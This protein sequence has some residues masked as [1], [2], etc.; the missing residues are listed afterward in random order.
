MDTT[1]IT[2]LTRTEATDALKLLESEQKILSLWDQL[3][4]LQ[5]ERALLEIQPTIPQTSVT[6][7]SSD[8]LEAELEAAEKA[9]LEARTT[10]M[11]R[12]NITTNVLI[13]DPILK[14]VHEASS[15]NT[16]ERRLLPLIHE[17]DA[18][19]LTHSHLTSKLRTLQHQYTTVEAEIMKLNSE[20]QLLASQLFKLTDALKDQ[21][22]EELD[23]P[24][25][26]AELEG[27]DEAV[28][29]ARRRWRVMKS[30]VAGIVVGSGVEWSR[31]PELLELVLDD[32][33]EGRAEAV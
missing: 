7:L 4:E 24:Q 11:L 9:L 31:R 17:R 25:L 5:L 27:L 2:S 10:Y 8:A 6:S 14:S 18:V 1:E 19:V 30:L 22:V 12:N 33:D 3:Q 28:K 15:A 21:T 16:I 26:T 13:A 32:E 29:K 23:D 20:N